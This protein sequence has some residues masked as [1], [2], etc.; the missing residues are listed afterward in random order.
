MA[1]FFDVRMWNVIMM[2]MAF[3]FMFTAFQTTSIIEPYV[4]QGVKEKYQARNETFA[5]DGYVSLGIVYAVFTFSNWFAPSFV[6]IFG[7]RS[8]MIAGGV[9]Y[10]LF[11]LSFLKPMTWTLYL[12]SVIIGLGASVI[13]TGQGNFLTLNSDT[14]TMSRNSGIFW[15]L[16]QCSLLFGNLFVFIMFPGKQNIDDHT[17]TTVFIVFSAVCGIGILLLFLLRKPPLIAEKVLHDIEGK[18]SPRTPHATSKPGPLAALKTSFRLFMTKDMILLSLCF[19]YTGLELTFFSGVYGT[20]VANTLK[21]PSAQK[22][23]GLVGVSIG[24]GEILGGLAFGIFGKKTNKFG[25]DPIVLLGLVVHLAA[26]LM[27]FLNIP[28][29]APIGKTLDKA[30]IK[31]NQYI[32]LI[33]AFLLGLGDSSFNTQIYSILGFAYSDDSAPAFALFKF[34]QSLFAAVGFFYSNRIQLQWQLLILVIWSFIGTLGFFTVEWKHKKRA[35][36]YQRIQ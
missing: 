12:A 1:G 16:L 4:L 24:V 33:C 31:P 32:A 28:S 3:M 5:G 15:A 34:T 2:G 36:G 35:V 22:I 13:W 19:A 23:I 21:I 10:L 29:H 20:S 8:S 17:R 25:R 11:I 9:C 30:Y 7:P 6:G 18:T 14:D 26:F 27:I